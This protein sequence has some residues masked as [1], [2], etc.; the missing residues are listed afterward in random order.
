MSQQAWDQITALATQ[1][2]CPGCVCEDCPFS[3]GFLM[4]DDVNR[5]GFTECGLQIIKS[6]SFTVDIDSARHLHAMRTAPAKYRGRRR[7]IA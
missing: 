6:K 5:I 2:E 3:I 1:A 4:L 7:G